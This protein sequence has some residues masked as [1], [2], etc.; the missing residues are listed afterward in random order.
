MENLTISQAMI[1]VSELE[2]AYNNKLF[3]LSDID[4]CVV[5]YILEADDKKYICNEPF[6]FE[7]EFNLVLELSNKIHQ[8]KTDIAKSNNTVSIDVLGTSM[9]I[10]GAINKS[11]MLRRE[12]DVFE[13]IMNNAKSSKQR[14]VDA[15]ATS[16]YYSVSEPNFDKKKLSELVEKIENDLLTLELAINKANNENV[17]TIA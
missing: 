13:E 14:K 9:T 15:A 10:Q 12:K 6:E 17:I 4:N 2:K 3:L 16:V 8:I 11:R 5:K 1:K 7:K